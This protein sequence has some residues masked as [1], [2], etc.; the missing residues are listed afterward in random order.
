MIPLFAVLAVVLFALAPAAV[1][2]MISHDSFGAAFRIREWWP[3]F[4]ANLLGFILAL[5]LS[6][7]FSFILGMVIQ[8][9]YF[10]IIL[11]IIVP[12]LMIGF[13]VYQLI[14]YSA[15]I[16]MAYKEGAALTN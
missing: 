3:I 13:T 1:G 2:H 4:R 5:V 11:C 9:L 7:G 14:V 16:G 12:F 8:F 6:F 10:T 15:L